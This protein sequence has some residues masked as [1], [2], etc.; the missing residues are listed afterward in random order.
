MQTYLRNNNSEELIIFFCG[1]GMDEKPF[2]PLKSDSDI[3]FL[4]DYIEADNSLDFDFTKYKK[5]S[6]IAFSYGVFMAGYLKDVLP[7]CDLKIAVNGTLKPV[8]EE[9]GIPEKIFTLTLEN[10]TELSALKFREKLFA[11]KSALSVFNKNLPNRDMKSSKDELAAL[12]NYF[13]K[14]KYIDFEYNKAIIAETDR[15]IPTK[16]QKNYWKEHRNIKLINSGV[17]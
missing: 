8:D 12:K 16:N 5:T 4:F 1:W 3:L 7:S 15:I 9:F 10:M 13:L 6:L 14:N 11:E 2:H 17:S